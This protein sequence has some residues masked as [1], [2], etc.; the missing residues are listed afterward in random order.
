MK[1][2]K[3]TFLLLLL[4]H[5]SNAQTTY[6]LKG[7]FPQASKKELVLK[8]FTMLGDSLLSKT[9][10]DDF[11]KFEI[12]Y[13]IKYR[14][15]ALLEIKESKSVIVLLNKEN[16]E[17]NWGNLEDF[18][19]LSYKNSPEN[20]A[21]FNGIAI[22]QK[23]EQLMSALKFIKPIYEADK[24]TS[25]KK[26]KW[27]AKEIAIQS[28]A[29]PDYLNSLS[30]NSYVRYFLK[31]RKLIE[32]MP[33][34]ASKYPERIP[35]HEEQFNAIDFASNELIRSGL[36]RE[37]LEGYFRLMESKG[38]LDMVYK[39]T[40]AGTDVVLKSLEKQPQLKQDVAQYLF[41]FF[42]KRSLFQAAEHLAFAMLD[43]QNCEMDNKHKALF[44]QY[45]KMA[46]GKTADDIVFENAT[47][48][49]TNL[50]TINAKYKLLVFGASWC[51]KC[52]E[53]IPKLKSYYEDW[54]SKYNLEIVF[55]SLD[56]EKSK[57]NEF[58]KDFPWLS[59]SELKGWEAKAALDYCVFGTPTMYLL[60]KNNTILLKPIS[61]KQVQSWLE[62]NEK[63]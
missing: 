38:D 1:S 13:P 31:L 27:V 61:E 17:M 49:V 16:F 47:Q 41:N 55:V 5:F 24:P 63:M 22:T 10:A 18:K 20:S 46:V 33:T 15:A 25:S 59:S 12:N 39:S 45:R 26:I 36:Y 4:V 52:Q 40:N 34:S 8:A 21:F 2:I 44:E 62:I 48:P 7:N 29:F 32:D 57:F 37:L 54:K 51:T 3:I 11:G 6:T 30:N 42:E 28:N 35:L 60:D 53:D 50:N 56:S 19:S 9:T 23:A 43:A 58:V 14:G